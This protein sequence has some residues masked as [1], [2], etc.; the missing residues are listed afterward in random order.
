MCITYRGAFRKPPPIYINCN[1]SSCTYLSPFHNIIR[2]FIRSLI[3]FSISPLL[4]A[5]KHQPGNCHSIHINIQAV[6]ACHRDRF[7]LVEKVCFFQKCRF[8][9]P[10]RMLCWLCDHNC[11]E[12]KPLGVHFRHPC[13]AFHSRNIIAIIKNQFNR[14]K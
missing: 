4:I 1:L 13:L 11:R 14:L 10:T 7:Q 12:A 3:F 5:V 2:L 6:T 8:S 9:I